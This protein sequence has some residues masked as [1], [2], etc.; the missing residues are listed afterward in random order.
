MSDFG[1][2]V[3]VCTANI[4]RSPMA[5]GLLAHAL[6][7]QGEPLN[8]LKVVSAGVSARPGERVSENSVIALRKVGIDISNHR[9]RPLTQRLLDEA[10]V[11]L[12]MT[13]S[14][15]AMIELQASP[16][17]KRL[18]LFREFLPGNGPI[19]IADPFGGSL[20]CYEQSRDEIVEAVPKVL[21]Y[22]KAVVAAP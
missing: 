16:V 11:V 22:L 3:V 15:R 19:E 2:I 17:P 5:E 4:C 8:Q 18:H 12:V 14:H 13:D 1:P 21:E 9:A 6:A 20:K 7:G 10:L